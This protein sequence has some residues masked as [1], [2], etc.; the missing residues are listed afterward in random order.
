MKTPMKPLTE[1]IKKYS[2]MKK[3]LILLCFLTAIGMSNTF[4]QQVDVELT[5]PDI[6]YSK[7]PVKQNPGTDYTIS[8]DYEWDS[9][10][11]FFDSLAVS[12]NG[13]VFA[14]DTLDSVAFT[15]IPDTLLTRTFKDTVVADFNSGSAEDA[16]WNLNTS[17]DVYAFT[18]SKLIAGSTGSTTGLTY[19]VDVN[20]DTYSR[21]D[22]T[23]GGSLSTDDYNGSLGAAFEFHAN[24]HLTD[25]EWLNSNAADVEYSFSI[26]TSGGSEVL[27]T[28][29]LLTDGDGTD[30]IALDL[31]VDASTTYYFMINQKT[32]TALT[33]THETNN[34]GELIHADGSGGFTVLSDTTDVAF[35]LTTTAN[36][37]PEFETIA[38]N[39]FNFYVGQSGSGTV[40]A[41]DDDGDALTIT[42]EDASP[43][44]NSSWLSFVDNGNGTGTIS[45]TPT[46]SNIGTV[47]ATFRVKDAVDSA[48]YV[49]DIRIS[50]Q[51]E[52]GVPFSQGFGNGTTP[53]GSIPT[54]WSLLQ[55]VD[56]SGNTNTWFES[57]DEMYIGNSSDAQNEV[58]VSAPIA[59][60]SLDGTTDTTYIVS[61]DLDFNGTEDNWA[62]GIAGALG[63]GS[64]GDG[65]FADLDVWIFGSDST[66]IYSDD[67]DAAAIID[68]SGIL[69]PEFDIS[70]WAGET[71][72]IAFQVT[73]NNPTPYS[74]DLFL[75]NVAINL[76]EEV[77]LSVIVRSDWA[78]IPASQIDETNG[79]DFHY[80]IISRGHTIPDDIAVT[81]NVSGD[82]GST[83]DDDFEAEFSQFTLGASDFTDGVYEAII[84]VNPNWPDYN[85]DFGYEVD[86]A[87][88]QADN[89]PTGST[90]ESDT[91]FVSHSNSQWTFI[92]GN[93]DNSMASTVF[94]SE[95][96]D[97]EF[98]IDETEGVGTI[99][100]LYNP[101]YLGGIVVDFN[102]G[103]A[104]QTFKVDIISIASRTA[105]SGTVVA[106]IDD[107]GGNDLDATSD[108]VEILNDDDFDAYIQLDAGLYVIMVTPTN[109]ADAVL[110][111]WSTELGDDRA[112]YGGFVRGSASNIY[113]GY[114]YED[115]TEDD[116]DI[117]IRA[118]FGDPINYSVIAYNRYDGM[119]RSQVDMT[120]G[121]DFMAYVI[122]RGA[123]ITDDLEL[124]M[125]ISREA[126]GVLDTDYE[127]IDSVLTLT[128]SDF[129]GDTAVITLNI[130]PDLPKAGHTYEYIFDA[131]V[132][133][134]ANNAWAST[135]QSV[136]VL[137][138]AD[139]YFFFGNSG[140]YD[141]DVT[142]EGFGKGLGE[143]FTIT[144]ADYLESVYV[145]WYSN[146]NIP[147]SISIIS[148]TDENAS[149]GTVVATINDDGGN[150]LFD[151]QNY[152]Y[153]SDDE[154]IA[155]DIYLTAGTYVVMINPIDPNDNMFVVYG[156][157]ASDDKAD[158]GDFVRGKSSNIYRKAD[159]TGDLVI[160]MVMGENDA[161]TFHDPR[162]GNLNASITQFSMAEIEGIAFSESVVIKDQQSNDVIS[163]AFAD[164]AP[165]FLTITGTS[166]GFDLEVDNTS[167]EGNYNTQVLATDGLDTAVLNVTINITPDPAPYF[168]TAPVV[169]A[170]EGKG[171]SYAATGVDPLGET[172]TASVDL[173]PAWLTGTVAGNTVTLTGT[174]NNTN[175]GSHV[176]KL[177]MTDAS[178][179]TAEQ[180]FVINVFANSEPF[181]T[182][183]P[184]REGNEG[185]SYFYR[186]TAS[187]DEG[188]NTLTF[189]PDSLPSGFVL[190]D[191]GNGI[192]E[193]SASTLAAGS[194]YVEISVSDGL[195]SISQSWTIEVNAANQPPI[196]TSVPDDVDTVN[197]GIV[198]E[199]NI[200]FEDPDGDNVQFSGNSLPSWIVLINE[201]AG[202]ARLLGNPTVEQVGNHNI[203]LR[204]TDG[205]ASATQIYTL[206]VGGEA[207]TGG[208]GGEEPSSEATN[209]D[210]DPTSA[211]KDENTD[212]ETAEAIIM[213]PNP[214]HSFLTIDNVKNDD[215][216][217][218]SIY[219]QA[220]ALIKS[221][222]MDKG[223]SIINIE[224]IKAGIYLVR[225]GDSDKL[226]RVVID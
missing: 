199:Y 16:T 119:P 147:L 188:N 215:Q 163:V 43:S 74:T 221:A 3:I 38:G 36:T 53:T 90:S 189:S 61:F 101:D 73:S 52:F 30:N 143:V 56:E 222:K 75:D 212:E 26:Y 32:T 209:E 67:D 99:I 138:D 20:D 100:E 141:I 89:N 116:G 213:Y 175:L 122:S 152:Y 155:D 126:D 10:G 111:I 15:S 49:V 28:P 72:R 94:G 11:A 135:N 166:S 87:I 79:H 195:V 190:T 7:I 77:D 177:L 112:D 118:Y 68:A 226:H 33:I 146:N 167:T 39:R 102:A 104:N 91:L 62:G 133:A 18:V 123:G 153:P 217:T 31:D 24:D 158:F 224:G 22:G 41:I 12:L 108:Y 69:T 140:E 181:F 13:N 225:V 198:Y 156:S 174:P 34:N 169:I 14:I 154:D 193:L 125:N 162:Q 170:F 178:G 103:T 96:N 57:G 60:P 76:N 93:I 206:N 25:F 191:V 171:Y 19:N 5:G 71:I 145:E 161:P 86:V 121:Y 54:T 134:T 21:Y 136:S 160:G 85:A 1:N 176:V 8:A 219:D 159:D 139:D 168:N 165:S 179:N 182:S 127:E 45:G 192:A 82:V 216:V 66:I 142:S 17:D 130:M 117:D 180:S 106:T 2:D 186:V 46:K 128:T 173:I 203:S 148:V 150:D 204:I 208:G 131:T 109:P 55:D 183:H 58:L 48:D 80:Y 88:S 149:S 29:I 202:H 35:T 78:E 201:G 65:N 114:T 98:T 164:D 83:A 37:A 113:S 187:D 151:D 207:P 214:A 9:I 51:V 42:L 218:V 200:T 50:D 70:D 81:I 197:Y 172:V 40:S 59:L 110:D 220:G 95:G 211:S 4:A 223:S 184:P 63:S 137:I 157:E 210:D 97:H 107:D 120:N 205:Q 144:S 64:N 23:N 196:F 6:E 44:F 115:D 185:D 194:H 92:D 129:S 84:T 27:T 105:T 132:S 47:Q 124:T